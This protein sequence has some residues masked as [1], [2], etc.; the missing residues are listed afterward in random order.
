MP[1][2]A[3]LLIEVMQEGQVV[4]ALFLIEEEEELFLLEVDLITQQI[5]TQLASPVVMRSA[6]V[7]A[8]TGPRRW[9]SSSNRRGYR[10]RLPRLV[11]ARK[12]VQFVGHGYRMG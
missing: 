5:A 7:A 11:T 2:G 3:G 1:H 6:F 10:L 4:A 9:D 8:C 12:M